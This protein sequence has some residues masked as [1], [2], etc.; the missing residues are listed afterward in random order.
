[1]TRTRIL[2]IISGE[3]GLHHGTYPPARFDK[4]SAA[5]SKWEGGLARDEFGD[6]PK[7]CFD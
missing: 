3:Y 6:F 5:L 7:Q 2:A 4:L 1:V